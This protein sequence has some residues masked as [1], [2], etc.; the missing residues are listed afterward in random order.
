MEPTDETHPVQNHAIVYLE[1]GGG[2][3]SSCQQRSKRPS[4]VVGCSRVFE[5]VCKIM[6]GR[7]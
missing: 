6:L 3:A 4:T 7:V 5:V 2:I 1:V